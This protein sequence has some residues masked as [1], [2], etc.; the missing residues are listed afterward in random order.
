MYRHRIECSIRKNQ[1]IG[2]QIFLFKVSF[3]SKN[4]LNE[5]NDFTLKD[6]KR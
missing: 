2:I 5:I 4:Y 6:K 1:E 3:Y